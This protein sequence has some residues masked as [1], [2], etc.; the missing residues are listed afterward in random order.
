MKRFFITLA[1][2]L[3][4]NSAH[5]GWYMI[6]D[7]NTITTDSSKAVG[8][9]LT[10]SNAAIVFNSQQVPVERVDGYIFKRVPFNSSRPSLGDKIYCSNE[11]NPH[12]AEVA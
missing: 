10:G 11:S 7:V 12:N 5:A 2:L 1:F 6:N 4:A 3:S 9:L 8:V